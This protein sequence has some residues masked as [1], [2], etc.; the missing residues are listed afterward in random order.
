MNTALQ[1]A[2]AGY[3]FFGQLVPSDQNR[4]VKHAGLQVIHADGSVTLRLKESSR[5]AMTL[6]DGELHT[7][8]LQDEYQPLMVTRRI[9]TWNDCDAVETW[10]E[11]KNDEN[12]PVKLLHSDSF[13]T[14]ITTDKETVEVHSLTGTWAYE[15]NLHVAPVAP[16]QIVEL[17]SC[18]GTR[19]AWES[20]AA[21]MLSFRDGEC[22]G[23]A[24]KD[25]F[26]EH[27]EFLGPARQAAAFA[28]IGMARR[29]R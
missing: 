5:S 17:R 3:L 15:A 13:A 7:I 2:M 1:I 4:I 27:G 9:R 18:E 20:N 28:V 12:G 19:D 25:Y 6:V 10:I 14:T 29:F 21:I 8:V 23:L 24:D 26:E 11:V 22:C 16:G